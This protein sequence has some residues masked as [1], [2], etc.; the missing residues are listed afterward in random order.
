MTLKKFK[1]FILN[2]IDYNTQKLFHIL[3]N[4]EQLAKNMNSEKNENID[5]QKSL[6]ALSD[7][8]K[9]MEKIMKVFF[10][11]MLMAEQSALNLQN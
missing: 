8:K 1:E 11:K 6:G 5:L 3:T 4:L 2:S 10:Q 7:S 9:I